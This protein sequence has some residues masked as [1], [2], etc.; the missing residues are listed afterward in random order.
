MGTA[1]ATTRGRLASLRMA[2]SD[3]VALTALAVIVAALI[4]ATWRAWGDVGS[5]TGYDMV[6]GARVAD[7]DVP[8]A[9]F[10]YYYGPLGP[11]L[12][13]L[14]AVVGGKG[15][16][17]QLVLGL[18]L[19]VGT[20]FATYAVARTGTG[21]LGSLLAAAIVAPVALGANNF[22][23]A[24]PHSYSA[25]LAVLCALGFL[26]GAARY[27]ATGRGL[28]LAAAGVAAGLTALTRPE[29]EV[30]VI[31]A[32]ALWLALR[33][34]TGLGG[35]R[36]I[37]RFAAPAIGIPVVVYGAFL[38]QV[39]FHRLVYENLY[40]TDALRAGGNAVLRIAA[41]LTAGSFGELALRLIL[42][43]VGAAALVALAM[44][45]RR[46]AR[47]R[48]P[49]LI[50]AAIAGVLVVA[51]SLARPEALRHALQFAYGW[52][53]AGAA[54]AA[55]ALV[56]V[57][58]RRRGDSW[59]PN[60][61]SQLALAVLLAVLAAKTYAAFFIHA[62]HAQAA[63]YALPFAAVFITW[64]HLERLAPLRTGYVLGALWIA[65][66]A[67]AGIGLGV[68]DASAKSAMVHGPGGALAAKPSEAAVYN[69]AIQQILAHSRPGEPVLLAPQLT[70]LYT[71]SGRTDPVPQLSLL[72][73]ALPSAGDQRAVVSDLDAAG[74]RLAV[75]DRH[76]FPEYGHTYFGGSFDRILAQW[77]RT[78]FVHLSTLGGGID[79]PT[80]DVWIRR[81][82]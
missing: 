21:P 54:I 61:Q 73:N 55:I 1:V 44:A 8:Y 26:W 49:G 22:S 57:R 43:A 34:R 78:N 28:H 37:L 14:F 6:A 38:T 59:S 32:A 74:V 71:L 82:A 69:A 77:I 65:F 31:G 20:V 33:W 81:A 63:V 17:P 42:Y 25:P 68:K 80:L 72:P 11:G 9:D 23:Y 47:L 15:L 75:I 40:P 50:V 24:V 53:P 27:A 45:P 12:A 16:T 19:A 5:D 13:G 10:T 62:T 64:L 35:P 76:R 66:L 30:A 56:W 18:L 51:G 79:A 39:S 67:V 36:E 52:I 48:R 2:L 7:G 46:A 70:S 4:A 29:F 41:P 58:V 3:R 60:A